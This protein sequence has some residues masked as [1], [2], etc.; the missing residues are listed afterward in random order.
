LAPQY[1]PTQQRNEKQQKC[2]KRN[3]EKP[4]HVHRCFSERGDASTR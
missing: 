3:Q 1:L 2:S 4:R